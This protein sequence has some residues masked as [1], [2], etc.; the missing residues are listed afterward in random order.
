[1]CDRKGA[2]YDGRPTGINHWRMK[3]KNIQIRIRKG[4]SYCVQS[5]DVFIVYLQKCI[6]EEGSYNED[7][8]IILQCE[9]SSKIMPELAKSSGRSVWN[10]LLTSRTNK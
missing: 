3:C 5:A 4:F 8:A 10:S 6:T 9:S 7:D 2:I 1:M